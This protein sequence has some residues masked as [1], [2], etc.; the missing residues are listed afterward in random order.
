MVIQ[1]AEIQISDFSG[2]LVG[3]AKKAAGNQCLNL[4][5]MVRAKLG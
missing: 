3:D 2:G 4:T 5:N 1:T